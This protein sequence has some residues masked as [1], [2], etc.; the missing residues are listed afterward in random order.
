MGRSKA[1]EARATHILTLVQAYGEARAKA[2][3]YR[4]QGNLTMADDWL[5]KSARALQ[6]VRSNIVNS[7][8]N[9]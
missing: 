4:E 8:H 2:A 7:L 3:T 9:L 1:I 5:G 6:L